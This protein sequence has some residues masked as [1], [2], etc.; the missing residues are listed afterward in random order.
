MTVAACRHASADGV[1][2][3]HRYEVVV[4]P[5]STPPPRTQDDDLFV[6][7]CGTATTTSSSTSSDDTATASQEGERTG[8]DDG[9]S[10]VVD[11]PGYTTEQTKP[12]I[13]WDVLLNPAAPTRGN[14]LTIFT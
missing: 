9:D 7:E 8:V 12:P 3:T 1:V 14:M 5:A 13:P 11:D 6:P 10:L 2:V 4:L